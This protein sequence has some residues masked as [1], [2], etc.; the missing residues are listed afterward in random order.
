MP[1]SRGE[2]FHVYASDPLYGESFAVRA[3]KGA[4]LPQVQP[5]KAGIASGV[6]IAGGRYIPP[7][8]AAE[9][10]TVD[11]KIGL[12]INGTPVGPQ[13]SLGIVEDK[14]I[15]LPPSGR[16][17]YRAET[18]A[19]DYAFQQYA[20]IW[21]KSGQPAAE[22]WVKEFLSGYAFVKSVV[23]SRNGL[24]ID[25]TLSRG[26]TV[27]YESRVPPP[28]IKAPNRAEM[29]EKQK[30][31]YT[32]GANELKQE[33][34]RSLRDGGM[35]IAP[36]IGKQWVSYF[37]ASDKNRILN[38]IVEAMREAERCQNQICRD[39]FNYRDYQAGLW[40]WEILLNMRYRD[41]LPLTSNL[42]GD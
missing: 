9:V 34:E 6:L 12:R 4:P 39:V 31:A 21:K 41:L 19:I 14:P 33:V 29:E 18:Q 5:K 1:G 7:P 8:Y 38:S 10:A 11:N 13:M 25:I 32:D 40:S 42:N 26:Q 35:V 22:K 2:V 16:F 24:R 23:F 3:A 27:S 15:Q 30:K 37:P 20:E 36:T 17:E 28:E